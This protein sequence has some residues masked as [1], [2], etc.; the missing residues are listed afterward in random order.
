MVYN[1]LYFALV[2]CWVRVEGEV[3]TGDSTVES[4]AENFPGARFREFG[5][6]EFGSTNSKQLCSRCHFLVLVLVAQLCA[7]EGPKTY[8]MRMSREFVHFYNYY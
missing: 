7:R 2:S 5:R 6:L 1:P 3:T 8:R 4:G